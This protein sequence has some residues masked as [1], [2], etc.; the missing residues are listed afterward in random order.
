MKKIIVA[1]ALFYIAVIGFEFLCHPAPQDNPQTAMQHY[2]QNGDYKAAEKMWNEGYNIYGFGEPRPFLLYSILGEM[3]GEKKDAENSERYHEL[4]LKMLDQLEALNNM[5]AD[6]FIQVLTAKVTQNPNSHAH[7]M[8][9][10]ERKAHFNLIRG[11]LLYQYGET[12]YKLAHY[13]K[14]SNLLK[15]STEILQN[16]EYPFDHKDRLE[17]RV[18]SL[19]A[20]A[21]NS[22]R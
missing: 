3:A 21:S 19:E 13:S 15:K 22:F 7:V 9:A 18:R 4:A 20:Q 12:E 10:A 5:D 1:I 11:L 6:I 14:A 17:A 8:N 16:I 2:L